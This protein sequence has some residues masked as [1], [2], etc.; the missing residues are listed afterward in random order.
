[1]AQSLG[2]TRLHLASPVKIT[3]IAP[4]DDNALLRRAFK[5]WLGPTGPG[6][7]V[8]LFRKRITTTD[9]VRDVEMRVAA[10]SYYHLWVNGCYVTRGPVFHHTAYLPVARLDLSP[11]WRQGENTVAVLV[12]TPGF[13][14]HH[15]QTGEPGLWAAIRLRDAGGADH[16]IVSDHSWKATDRVGWRRYRVRHGW[17]LGPVEV[18]DAAH[19]TW[20][21]QEPDFDDTGWPEAEVV[22]VFSHPQPTPTEVDLPPLRFGWAQPQRLASVWSVSASAAPLEPDQS[23]E[24]LGEWLQQE[25]WTLAASGDPIARWDQDA[26]RLSVEG[27]TPQRGLAVVLDLGQEQVGH[28]TFDCA[29]E[30]PGIVEIAWS[31]VMCNRRPLVVHKGTTYVDRLIAHPGEQ[32]WE[33]LQF[34][35]LRYLVLILRGFQGSVRFSRIGIRTSTSVPKIDAH[36]EC[37]D[38]RLNEIWHLCARTVCIG[39]QETV[40]DCPSREQAPY[41]GDGNLVGRWIGVFNHDYRHWRYLLRLGFDSQA[42]DGLLR[43]APLFPVQR[44]LLDYVLL[45]VVA[46]RDYVEITGERNVGRE[47]LDGCCRAIAYFDRRLG[48]DGLLKAFQVPGVRQAPWD[49]PGPP[50]RVASLDPHLFIDHPGLGGHNIGDAG[51]ERRGRSGALN[52]LYVL[53]LEAIADLEAW[54]GQPDEAQRRRA[55]AS[56]VRA[57][58]GAAYWDA[59]Q[60]VFRD[61]IDDRGRPYPQ[62]SEQTNVLAAM[63]EL[64]GPASYAD[65]ILRVLAPDPDIARCGP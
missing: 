19:H 10:E 1:M 59:R 16:W 64:P 46:V 43:D 63:A 18:L 32:R 55:V 38:S 58:A 65:L 56:R 62:V 7:Q 44:A 25:P 15:V 60:R 20:G 51:I 8:R 31:E 26:N 35:G 37:D 53:A 50:R 6:F 28:I 22:N 24:V 11:W 52:A 12:F 9:Q 13:P 42:N 2:T 54:V 41:L 4:P 30:S 27:L 39:T 57:A 49:I 14:T 48:A 29:C 3:P 33:A 23:C 61:A 5:L 36:F 40:M 47:L 17:A 45:T 34:T 21:W